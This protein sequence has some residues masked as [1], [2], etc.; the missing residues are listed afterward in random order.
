M[1]L[2]LFFLLLLLLTAC[3]NQTLSEDEIWNKTVENMNQLENYSF[4]GTM[5]H[6][7]KNNQLESDYAIS[8]A[9]DNQVEPFE[10]TMDTTF[11]IHDESQQYK[12][13]YIEDTVFYEAES[14]EEQLIKVELDD[15][16]TQVPDILAFLDEHKDQLTYQEQAESYQYT[17]A[18]DSEQESSILSSVY[19]QILSYAVFEMLA[20][21]VVLEDM[22]IDN[23]VVDVDIDKDDYVISEIDIAFEGKGKQ[24]DALTIAQT[25]EYQLFDHNQVEE[26]AIPY[27]KTEKAVTFME[28]IQGQTEVAQEERE[29]EAIEN[30]KKSLG[31]THGNLMNGGRWATDGEWIYYSIFSDGLFRMSMDGTQR[32]R[33]TESEATHINIV[34]D[35]LF[36]IDKSN[37]NKLSKIN[38]GGTAKEF[39]ND[40]SAKHLIATKEWLYFIELDEYYHYPLWREKHDGSY[41]EKV[42]NKASDF[43]LNGDNM[44]Y[45]KNSDSLLYFRDLQEDIYEHTEEEFFE[46]ESPH[47]LMKDEWLYFEHWKADNKIYRKNIETGDTEPLTVNSSYSFNMSDNYIFYVNDNDNFSLYRYDLSSQEEK[48]LVDGE[49]HYIH[50]IEDE[51]FFAHMPGPNAIDWYRMSFDGE[52]QEKIQ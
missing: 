15:Q 4:Q 41:G 50:I 21:E 12:T 23:L 14:E 5:E 16:L 25:V 48:K 45:T 51:L 39:I 6:I 8:I 47:Y 34:D 20:V 10:A 44:I 33:I 46:L 30:E 36:F 42:V 11:Q 9:G 38:K 31:H 43:M 18:S 1:K 17:Y 35:T 37:E 52:Q 27:E 28:Y 26:L 29:K 19:P 22:N 24:A 40:V 7:E 32:H 49:V 13:Y 2:K 3:S